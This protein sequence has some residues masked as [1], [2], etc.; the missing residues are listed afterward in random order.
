MCEHQQVNIRYKH[1]IGIF[2][3]VLTHRISQLYLLFVLIT[4]RNSM[5]NRRSSVSDQGQLYL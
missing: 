1:D 2:I 4:E 5:L 3:I